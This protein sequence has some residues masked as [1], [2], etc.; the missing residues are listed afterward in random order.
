MNMTAWRFLGG[1]L[2]VC[3]LLVTTCAQTRSGKDPQGSPK[4]EGL[5]TNTRYVVGY[6]GMTKI[7]YVPYLLFKDGTIYQNMKVSP[8]DLDVKRSRQSEPEMWGRWQ[9]SGE[10]IKVQWN[11]G[12][13]ETW[14]SWYV[15]IPARRN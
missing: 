11:D 12:H 2:T 15:T 6:G 3:A 9:K 14:N 8:N 13:N 7:Y 5:Y 10:L 4:I 1:A